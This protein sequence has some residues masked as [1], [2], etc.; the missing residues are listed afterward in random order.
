VDERERRVTDLC[1]EAVERIAGTLGDAEVGG[2]FRV[3]DTLRHVAHAGKLRVIY[4][5][6]REQGGVAWRAAESGEMQRV[7]DVRS[8][9]DYLA[10]DERVR[11]EIVAP[12]HADGEVVL[13]L[14]VEFPG[15]VFT[16]EEAAAIEAE[17]KRLGSRLEGTA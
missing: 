3:G 13:V 4:E 14:D 12:V 17:A 16:P 1:E 10:S 5:V 9:P 7:E 15:R 8:D 6:R 11:S 2:L